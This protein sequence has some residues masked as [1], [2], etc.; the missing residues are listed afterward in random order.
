MP[1]NG[2]GMARGHSFATS[3][4]SASARS[5]PVMGRVTGRNGAG[6]AS[7]NGKV[8]TQLSGSVPTRGSSPFLVGTAAGSNG[9]LNPEASSSSVGNS[10][11][12]QGSIVR[13]TPK[14][15]ISGGRN[16]PL[17]LSFSSAGLSSSSQV[18]EGVFMERSA[19]EQEILQVTGV[20]WIAAPPWHGVELASMSGQCAMTKCRV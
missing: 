18:E 6:A 10:S 3:T 2:L 7:G 4:S 14:S 16:E 15:V 17:T 1:A 5:S 8:A 13:A 12:V 19:E 9:S 20:V 11:N